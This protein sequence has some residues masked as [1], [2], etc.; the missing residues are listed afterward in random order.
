MSSETPSTGGSRRAFLK[1]FG[2][3]VCGT[4]A[5]AAVL[6]DL[7]GC[8]HFG[9]RDENSRL[10]PFGNTDLR[11]SRLCQGTAFRKVSR[12]GNDPEGQRILRHAID[13][14][15]NFFDTAEA[16]GWGGSEKA[17]GNA[18]RGKRNQ[19]V[20]ATKAA[21]SD[22]PESGK[23]AFTLERLTRKVEGSLQRLGTQ[24]IDIYLL[25]DEDGVTPAADIAESMDT[26][27]RAGKIRYWGV[28]NHSAKLV[29]ELIDI[30]NKGGTVP[31]AGL[32]D[33]YNIV[34]A[35][36]A[37]FMDDEMFPLIH[38]GKLGLMAFSPLGEG[39][40]APGRSV[41]AGSPVEKVIEALDH[42]AKEL[43]ATR[44]QVCV[45]WVLTRPEVTSV[46][47]GAEKP[48]HVSDNFKGTELVIPDAALEILDAA[49]A[50]YTKAMLRQ[51]TASRT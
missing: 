10:V 20:I 22:G 25:H 36:R 41:E 31:I 1:Q 34:A 15:V 17:L 27:V 28:S 26:L 21:V 11:V 7:T 42:V 30:G 24:H 45:A 46:L 6:G 29:S 40:L 2:L 48:E 43:G 3:R 16:Y 12:E 47:A 13:I 37:V 19:L 33:Y 14:G 35:D 32:E 44:P 18:I 23:S 4:V 50:A 8:S 5:G 39:R 49:S 38:R 9:S 51:R